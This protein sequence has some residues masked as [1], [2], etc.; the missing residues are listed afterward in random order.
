M[1]PRPAVEGLLK[2][3]LMYGVFSPV[4]YCMTIWTFKPAYPVAGARVAYEQGAIIAWL[5]SHW[6][7]VTYNQV[8]ANE[9][10]TWD[11]G[12]TPPTKYPTAV[13]FPAVFGQLPL[14]GGSASPR[15]VQAVVALR[16]QPIGSAIRN[17][18]NGRIFHTGLQS[19]T[20]D[21]LN[22]PGSG[23]VQ[24]AY[25]NLLGRLNTVAHADS[26]NW[27]VPSFF[28][29]GAMRVVPVITPINHVVVRTQPG[30]QRRRA[31]HAAAYPRGT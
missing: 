25:T 6:R 13:V 4:E 12:T 17:R 24:D 5:T 20:P 7:A 30:I 1:P 9:V 15:A 10:R 3:Q 22:V 23:N 14:T 21:A 8:N 27:S 29:G 31:K 16:T 19:T 18:L 26:G 28:E 2:H 11:F